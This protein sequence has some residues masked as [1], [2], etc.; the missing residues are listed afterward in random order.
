[1]R[2]QHLMSPIRVGNLI[3]KNRMLCSTSMPHTLQGSETYPGEPI[4]DHFVRTAKN[5]AAIVSFATELGYP[6]PHQPPDMEAHMGKPLDDND[7]N[8]WRY[9]AQLVDSVHFCGSKV[10][11]VIAPLLPQGYGIE[12]RPEIHFDNMDEMAGLD[13]AP[14]FAGFGELKEASTEMLHEAVETYA[15]IVEKYHHIG[16]DLCTIHA[17]YRGSVAAQLMSPITNH[18]TD[19][20]GCGS[21]EDRARFAME[22]CQRIKQLCGRKF[23][24]ELQITAEERPGGITLEDT[25]G[26][27]KLFESCADILQIRA[28]TG[29]DAHPTG[30]NSVPGEH[31]TLKYAEA[32]KA[33]GTK[34]LVV[35]VGGY[36]DLEEN[37]RY[38]AEGKCD[39]IGMARAFVCDPEYGKK[40]IEGRG[41]DVVPCLRCNR[42]HSAPFGARMDLIPMCSVNPEIGRHVRLDRLVSPVDRVKRV[43]VIGGGPA[44]L[45]AALE[46]RKRGHQVEVFEASGALGGQLKHA[47]VVSFKWPLAKFKE[48]LIAQVEKA[49]IPVHLNT[50]ASAAGLDGRFDVIIA[51]LGAVPKK[52]D[53]PGADLS[54]VWTPHDVYGREA[55]L[56]HRVAVVGGASTGTE[57]AV[58][59]ADLGHDVTVLTRQPMLAHDGQVVHFYDTMEDYWKRLENFHYI[60][61]AKTQ[62][63][64]REGVIYRDQAG[65]EHTVCADSVV[66]CG[67]VRPLTDEA[68]ALSRAA[69]EFY[70]IGDCETPGSIHECMQTAHAAA[71]M[72]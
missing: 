6:N 8:N 28:A 13:G 71:S 32:I 34:L 56:G 44:G 18:R 67:G 27:A 49:G 23:P 54:N 42:C 64:T 39:M 62:A 7:P 10:S 33:S 2:Y 31:L 12:Y 3:L 19:C 60:T 36:Q 68:L 65:V 1:M 21:L 20:Y 53:L 9:Y 50:R 40:A 70:L 59:L 29:E 30:W 16:F 47:D 43:A 72:I 55:E 63:I 66:L 52:P 22:L 37:D 45:K 61:L 51:A 4:I 25:I 69:D 48:H 17:S 58:H 46:V 5:G 38:I 41:E 15:R 57:T 24:V 35:P 26:F 14:P 11:V